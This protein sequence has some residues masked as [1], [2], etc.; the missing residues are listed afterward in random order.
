MDKKIQLLKN[1]ILPLENILVGS[2]TK[3]YKKCGKQYCWCMKNEKYLHGPYYIWT[4]KVNSKTVTKTLT[5]EQAHYCNNAIRNMKLLK[6]F[7]NK[8]KNI[9]INKIQKIK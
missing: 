2:I 8:W 4:R 6:K 9:S 5:K 1:K 7:I 3:I